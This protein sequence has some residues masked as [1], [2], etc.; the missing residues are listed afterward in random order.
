MYQ[1]A[2]DDINMAVSAEPGNSVYLTEKCALMLRVNMLDEAIAAARQCVALDSENVDAYRMLGYALLQK[3]D[4]A[5]ALE[6]LNR[7]ISLGDEGAK[8]IVDKY[9]K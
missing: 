2:I 1:Q 7:A 5:G 3:G 6:N 8:E 4:K 9:M